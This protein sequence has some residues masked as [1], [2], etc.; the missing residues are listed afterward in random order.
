MSYTG[1]VCGKAVAGLAVCGTDPQETAQDFAGYQLRYGDYILY[2][3]RGANETDRLCASAASV[4]LTAGKAGSMA[5]TLPPDH[6]YRDKL[7]YMRPGLELLQG[8]HVVWRGRITSQV[9]DFRNSLN[10]TAEGV[11]AVLNDSTV[12]PFVYPDDFAEDAGYQAAANNGNV[13][14][15]LFRWF[16]AQHNAKVSTDQQ[17]KPGVCTVTDANNYIA[18]SATKYL[19]TMEAMTTRLTGSALGGYLLMRYE[20]DGNYL[21]YYADLPLT[22]AQAV[23][24]GQ[25]LLDLERQLTG[26]GIYTAILPV[27]HDGLTITELQDGDITDD[28]VKEGPYVWSRAAV[29]KYGWICPGPTDWRDVTVAANLQS[30]AAARLATSGWALE[31]SITCKA[32]DLHVTD[33]AVAAWR[34]G[35]YTMLATTPHGIRAAMPLLQM[36]VDLLDPAQTTVTM[37]RTRRTFTD[38]V[39]DERRKVTQEM[40]ETRTSTDERINTVQ[41]ILTERMTQ[42]SQSDR[43]ILLEALEQYVEIGDFESYKRV[44]DATLTVLPDQIRMEVSEEITEQVE[45]ATGDIRQSVRTMNQYMS[46]TAAMG[47]L[48]GSEG[49]PVK[50][51]INNQGLNIL[52][53]T[54][55][56]LSINQRGVYTPSL[57]IR[58]MDP[59]DPTAGCLYL[60]NLVVRVAPDGSVVGAKG[61]N[62]NG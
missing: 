62:A 40:E 11:M 31:E 45:D 41:Q 34:V 23:Q 53:E 42:I 19:T 36:H 46:F 12:P 1:A 48:L 26:T 29:Q 18:R 20:A 51:Q 25:N 3:P 14:D 39:E 33:A 52:R 6:P 56:L 43:Q 7:P 57:Y 60:G 32:I 22:N 21:D 24:F 10:V 28:L 50:V 27:G 37:G 44:M 5:F 59:D 47:M 54:L 13:V 16:L 61:V 55:A 35:R 30:Y 49:D 4:D 15:F 9:G 17:I 8:R 38:G 2:D 58:P